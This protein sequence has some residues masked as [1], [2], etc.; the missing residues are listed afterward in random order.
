GPVGEL[1]RRPQESR[2]QGPERLPPFSCC[3]GGC[4]DRHQLSPEYRAGTSE[5]NAPPG[6]S[7]RSSHSAWPGPRSVPWPR[8]MARA[9]GAPPVLE[10]RASPLRERDRGR[11]R[12]ARLGSA[13]RLRL[14]GPQGSSRGEPP[15]PH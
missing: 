4:Q 12:L 11:R 6:P 8:P 7:R 3:R 15:P 2:I 1:L 14:E 9:S 5:T 10:V 13:A